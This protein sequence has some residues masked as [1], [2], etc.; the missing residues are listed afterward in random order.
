MANDGLGLVYGVQR[1]LQQY[2]RYIVAVVSIDGGNRSTWR[3]P[4]T[5]RKRLTQTLSHTV[6]SSTPRHKQDSNSQPYW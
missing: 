5:W 3:K 4:L 2:L 1:H 6:I